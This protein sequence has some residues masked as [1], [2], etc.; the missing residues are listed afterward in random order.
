MKTQVTR[1]MRFSALL[2]LLSIIISLILVK[3][4]NIEDYIS[5]N[6]FISLALHMILF[7]VLVILLS[8]IYCMTKKEIQFS[9]IENQ[10]R[11]LNR[12]GIVLVEDDID[13]RGHLRGML[14]NYCMCVIEKVDNARLLYGFDIIILDIMDASTIGN[15]SIPIIKE[16]YHSEPYKY[17]IA[18]SKSK[19]A[20]DKC[21]GFVNAVVLKDESFDDTL[22]KEIERAFSKLDNPQKYWNSVEEKIR[23]V[24]MRDIHK[25]DYYY[26]LLQSENFKI[27]D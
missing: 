11:T 3:V 5:R 25:K 19:T 22:K 15:T 26:N 16:L 8:Y 9:D 17:V 14:S 7:A 10:N 4:T 20:L 24:N 18:M 6:P 23:D 2:G 21:Q 12:Y 27:K 13:A 1:E